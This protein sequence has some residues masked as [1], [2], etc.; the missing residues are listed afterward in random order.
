MPSCMNIRAIFIMALVVLLS[1]CAGILLLQFP[2]LDATLLPLSI[3]LFTFQGVA[4]FVF[5]VP[6]NKDVRKTYSCLQKCKNVTKTL[7]EKPADKS[8]S[9][10]LNNELASAPSTSST[11]GLISVSSS[12]FETVPSAS[13]IVAYESAISD[14]FVGTPSTFSSSDSDLGFVISNEHIHTSGP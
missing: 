8:N 2:A 10:T 5:L 9:L 13:N 6:L 1:L 7:I 3:T 4:I 14:D 11:S 12:E